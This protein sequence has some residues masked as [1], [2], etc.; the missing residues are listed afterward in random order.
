MTARRFRLLLSGYYGFGNFGDEAILRV[1]VD[2]WRR[3]RPD[4][5]I[6][7]LSADPKATSAAFGVE[8]APRM[9]PNAVVDAIRAADLVV[10]G[11]GGLLQ[12][13]TSL[14]SLMYYA[15]IIAEAKR[16]GKTAAIFAQGI[17]PLDFLGKQVVKRSCAGV[18]L[19]IVRDDASAALL[20]QILPKVETTVAADPVFLADRAVTPDA[21][22][23]LDRSGIA[24]EHGRLI[25]VVVRRTPMLGRVIHELARAV[26]RLATEHRATV[27]FVPF[28]RPD[29]A[30]AAIDVIRRCAS[31]PTLVEC[32]TDLPSMTALFSRCHAVI[33][34]R[35][36]AVILAARLGVPFLAIPYDPKVTAAA[37]LVSYPLPMFERGADGAALADAL[38]ARRDELAAHLASAVE[39]LSA[40]AAAGFDRLAALAQGA[41]SRAW[42]RTP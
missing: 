40:S 24:S 4:D 6:D 20:G 8:A 14:R 21:S 1:F 32:G 34:M 9:R 11:G 27:V 17:G 2:E 13:S 7:V 41:A 35:L 25:A 12:S 26:D 38:I 29:D 15:G 16:A 36:H 18:D 33:A 10:S 3:R 39:P 30:E 23:A 28:Q 19:A 22:A 5:E 42:K 37:S 31:A